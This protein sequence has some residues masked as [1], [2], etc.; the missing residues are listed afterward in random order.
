MC[1]NSSI[2][3]TD[4]IHTLKENE[5]LNAMT[6]KVGDMFELGIVDPVKVTRNSFL[7]AMSIAKLFLTT[8]VA[9]LR[10]E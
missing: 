1:D 4:I 5:S 2:Y 7:A 6:G 8:E 3:Y 10:E 9:V